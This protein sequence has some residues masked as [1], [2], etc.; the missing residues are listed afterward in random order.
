MG[1]LGLCLAGGGACPV[2]GAG[3]LGLCPAL[4]RA[5]GHVPRREWAAWGRLILAGN[6]GA[7]W[8]YVQP[9]SGLRG[10]SRGG[11]AVQGEEAQ[12]GEA[13]KFRYSSICF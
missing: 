12:L 7:F 4:E 1:W 11:A 10:M 5:A 6:E 2:A 8:G 13:G 9:L 3:R